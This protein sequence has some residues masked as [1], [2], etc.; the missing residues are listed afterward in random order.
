M[1]IFLPFFT[2]YLQYCN[3]GR[4]GF[5]ILCDRLG[6]EEWFAANRESLMSELSATQ[7]EAEITVL[8]MKK[9]R[10]LLKVFSLAVY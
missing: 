1:G 2:Y 3:N 6:F 4:C 10:Q 7:D 8:A 9:Y 5:V